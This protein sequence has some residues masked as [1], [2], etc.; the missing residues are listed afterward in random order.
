MKSHAPIV[1]CCR[2]VKF[3]PR[4]GNKQKQ[5]WQNL[6]VLNVLLL[7]AIPSLRTIGRSPDCLDAPTLVLGRLG[8]LNPDGMAVGAFLLIDAWLTLD[9]GE[10][11]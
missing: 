1:T 5:Y 6:F 3:F 7:F 9:D 11:R 8:G 4:R 10:T 2:A